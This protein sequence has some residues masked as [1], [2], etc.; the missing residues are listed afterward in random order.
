MA[1]IRWEPFQE[2]DSLQREMNRLFDSLLPPVSPTGMDE[3][4]RADF[5]PAAELQETA[6]EIILRVEIPG[7]EAKD[8][9]VQVMAE[10]VAITGE[11]RSEMKTEEQGITHSEFRYG[12]FRRVIP[13]PVRIQNDQVKAECKNGVLGLTLPKAEAEKNRVVKVQIG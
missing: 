12:A 1:L 6:N 11:R 10:A 9:E 3:L 2:I 5:I 7:I 13:L 4:N 8:L